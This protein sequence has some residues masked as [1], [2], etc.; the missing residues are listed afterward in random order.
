MTRYELIP[1]PVSGCDRNHGVRRI[2]P[3]PSSGGRLGQPVAATP[4]RVAPVGAQ[5][6]GTLGGRLP[7]GP[8]T[9]ALKGLG[10]SGTDVPSV[11]PGH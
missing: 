5:P 10:T 3:P 1:C 9:Q 2:S 6:K 7:E 8:D 4:F 11:R